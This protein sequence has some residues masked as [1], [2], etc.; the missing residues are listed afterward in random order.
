MRA[1]ARVCMRAT[2]SCFPLKPL[3]WE[4][5]DRASGY[6]APSKKNDTLL[7]FFEPREVEEWA[8]PPERGWGRGWG[9][10]GF[11][12]E[13]ASAKNSYLVLTAGA[14]RVQS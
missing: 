10:H 14:R 3:H 1:C 12:M 7:F 4:Q 13:A 11:G 8:A 6:A 9:E 5:L 2:R